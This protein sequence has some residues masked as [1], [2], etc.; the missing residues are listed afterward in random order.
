MYWL[1][2]CTKC[3][4]DLASGCDQYGSYVSCMQCGRYQDIEIKKAGSLG[5][6]LQLSAVAVLSG[7]GSRATAVGTLPGG[8]S[9]AVL[10]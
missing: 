1:K 2:G 8:L 3:G 6:G 9:A 5:V 10:A 7:E 4:G